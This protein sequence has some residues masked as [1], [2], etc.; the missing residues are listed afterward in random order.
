MDRQRLII[1]GSSDEPAAQVS[2][3]I[4]PRCLPFIGPL[5]KFVKYNSSKEST[6]HT[7][8]ATKFLQCRVMQCH[9]TS[10]RQDIP[11]GVSLFSTPTGTAYIEQL[12]ESKKLT[13]TATKGN[14]VFHHI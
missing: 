2:Y 1:I 12:V 8:D 11:I 5:Y 6:P 10:D 7:C 3:R 13:R 4:A 9:M 14:T